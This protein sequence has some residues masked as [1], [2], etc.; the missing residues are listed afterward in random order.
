MLKPAAFLDRDGVINKE[1]GYL[2]KVDDFEWIEGARESIK[3]LND[4]GYYVFIV[5][6]QSGIAKG[7][8][9]EI[10]VISLHAYITEELKIIDAHIDEFFISPYHPDNTIDYL[11][12]SHMRKPD[13]GML[14]L[15]ASKWPIDKS[16]SFLIGDKD[17]DIKSAEKFSIRGHL[18]KNGNLLEFIKLSENI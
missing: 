5:T 15:A 12:L 18:Y 9:S 8:Y 14:N 11:H 7:Y 17:T 4:I 2:Y 6:N 3:Y 13:I 10:D 16:K 1:K